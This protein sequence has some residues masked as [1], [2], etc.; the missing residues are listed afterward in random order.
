MSSFCKKVIPTTLFLCIIFMT[1]FAQK[2]GNIVEYFGREVVEEINEG[3]VVHVF[4]EGLLLPAASR[5]R[6]LMPETDIVAWHFANGTWNTPEQ[7]KL[8][9]PMYSEDDSSYIWQ[10]IQ[11]NDENSFRKRMLWRSFLYT[12]FEATRED[13]LLLDA[14]G[15]TQGYI[16]G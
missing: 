16:N 7:G 10:N 15:H 3:A 4:D 11:A 2:E 5:G 6:G 1:S 12:S 14:R 9:H 8:L 13:V